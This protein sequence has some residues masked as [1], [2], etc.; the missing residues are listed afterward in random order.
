[1]LHWPLLDFSLHLHL[2]MHCQL[3]SSCCRQHIL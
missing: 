2:M 1:M 3:L